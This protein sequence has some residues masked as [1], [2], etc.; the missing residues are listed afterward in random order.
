L[1]TVTLVVYYTV[2]HLNTLTFL[3]LVLVMWGV[4]LFPPLLERFL[5]R[6]VVLN[7]GDGEV[8]QRET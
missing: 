5:R 6:N 8:A 4:L 3:G 2:G 1:C 7:A